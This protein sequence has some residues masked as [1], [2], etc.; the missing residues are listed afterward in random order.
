M[1]T[2]TSKTRFG[3]MCGCQEQTC[4]GDLGGSPGNGWTGRPK[5]NNILLVRWGVTLTVNQ[6]QDNMSLLNM[7]NPKNLDLTVSQTQDSTDLTN[8]L[9]L[10]SL[11]LAVSQVQGSAGDL[12][13][14][15]DLKNLDFTVSQARENMDL[16]NML[17]PKY[18]N[19]TIIKF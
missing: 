12:P 10:K 6:V 9:D 7:L 8:M 16:T 11:N 17:D 1:L 4:E 14:M 15:L 5:A 19:S 18:L 2:L 3:A 13:N